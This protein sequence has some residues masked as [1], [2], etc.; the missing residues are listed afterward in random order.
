MNTISHRTV[1]TILLFMIFCAPSPVGAH[2]T[3]GRLKIT[4]QEEAIGVDDVAYFAESFVHRSLYDD[5]TAATRNRFVI[6][7]FA[8][9]DQTGHRAVIRFTV[10]DK[11][12]NDTFDDSL[13]IQRDENG[14]WCHHP[15]GAQPPVTLYSYVRKGPYYWEKYGTCVCIVSVLMGGGLLVL[16][17]LSQKRRHRWAELALDD[18][19]ASGVITTPR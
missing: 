1:L 8:G 6:K 2:S 16:M 19:S 9:V 14:V 15:G 5:G 10:L 17:R 13:A 12:T 18:D 4:L 3:K 11:K 7:N